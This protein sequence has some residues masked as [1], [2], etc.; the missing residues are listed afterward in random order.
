M[1]LE[2][3]LYLLGLILAVL[4]AI[5]PLRTFYLLNAAVVS[6][7]IGLVLGSGAIRP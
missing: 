5:P 6:L 3:F 2:I 7:A 1:S 4:A